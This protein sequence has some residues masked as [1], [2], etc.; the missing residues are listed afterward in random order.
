MY[1]DGI[2]AKEEGCFLATTQGNISAIIQENQLR[3]L[4]D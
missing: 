2:M 1:L 4:R 3:F